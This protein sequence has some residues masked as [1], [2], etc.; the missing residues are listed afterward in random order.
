MKNVHAI[1]FDLGGVILN[2]DYKLTIAAFEKLGVKNAS[3]F[4]SKKMQHPIF[5]EIEIGLITASFFLEKLEKHCITASKNEVEHA[6]N[7]MLLDLPKSRLNCIKKLRRKYKVFLLSNTNEIHIKAFRKKFTEKSWMK[8]ISL[9]NKIYFS[10]KIGCRKPDKKAF[11]IIL[12]ENDLNPSNVLFVDDSLQHIEGAKNLGL[13]THHLL[14]N[15]E[16]MDL[17]PDI[18]L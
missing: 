16:I 18:I 5:D 4:Y 7:A 8:F 1:I 3:S 11:E 9:F 10:H 17:F 15:E 6:W 2:I 14:N 12:E 13:Q